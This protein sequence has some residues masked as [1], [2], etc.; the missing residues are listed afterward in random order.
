MRSFGCS[1]SARRVGESQRVAGCGAE[2]HQNKTPSYMAHNHVWR[3]AKGVPPRSAKSPRSFLNAEERRNAEVLRT[4]SRHPAQRAGR[5]IRSFGLLMLR[6][7]REPGS[8]TRS[9]SW[10][11]WGRPT[12][13]HHI[14]QWPEANPRREA[15]GL[16]PRLAKSLRS[17]INAEGRRNAEVLRTASRHSAQRAGRGIRSFGLLMLRPARGRVV[18]RGGVWG[19]APPKQD[20]ILHGPQPRMARSKCRG[21]RVR[22]SLRVLIQT[23]RSGATRRCSSPLRAIQ[24]NGPIG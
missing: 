15:K 13:I 12:K 5:G 21:L 7:A 16:P 3:E 17:F 2:P 24:H 11:G 6:P 4:A 19:A 10:R 22:P 20:S 9:S 8:R 1:C 23:R 18:T 14:L